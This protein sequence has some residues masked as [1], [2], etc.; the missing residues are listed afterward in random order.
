MPCYSEIN[1]AELILAQCEGFPNGI[2]FMHTVR[3][4]LQISLHITM[5]AVRSEYMMKTYSV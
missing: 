2:R 4:D 1:D 3:K 5:G